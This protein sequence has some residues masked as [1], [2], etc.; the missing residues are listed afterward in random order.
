MKIRCKQCFAKQCTNCRFGDKYNG[1]WNMKIE[2]I[3]GKRNLY[4]RYIK[5]K[6]FISLPENEQ[7]LSQ[8]IKKRE[9]YELAEVMGFKVGSKIRN[10]L[11]NEIF[12]VYNVKTHANLNVEHMVFNV[13]KADK[14]TL[15]KV[16]SSINP[17]LSGCVE[18]IYSSKKILYGL[19]ELRQR[20]CFYEP[21]E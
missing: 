11:T 13:Y 10:I 20:T 12:I 7:R 21:V 9:I 4:E 18:N 2:E 19:D 3:I 1:Y 16:K 17:F 15:A 5:S 8:E 6:Y 14:K